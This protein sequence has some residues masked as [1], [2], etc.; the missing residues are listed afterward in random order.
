MHFKSSDLNMGDTTQPPEVQQ[1]Y[2]EPLGSS[3]NDSTPA[4]S[5]A[6]SYSVVG[7]QSRPCIAEH[8]V[9]I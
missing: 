4:S 3:E 9:R 1:L 6:D 8:E 2:I 7:E 5:S